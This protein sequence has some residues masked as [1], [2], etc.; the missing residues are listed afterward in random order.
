MGLFDVLM[1]A[2][3]VD[4]LSGHNRKNTNSS[5][6]SSSWNDSYDLGCD[7]DCDFHF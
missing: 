4:S 1:A 6:N 5:Y 3:I 2:Y 7:D